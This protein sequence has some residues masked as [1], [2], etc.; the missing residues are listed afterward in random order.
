M[1]GRGRTK[2]WWKKY[3]QARGSGATKEEAARSASIAERRHR[4]KKRSSR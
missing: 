1:P 3:E 2:Y 4:Q